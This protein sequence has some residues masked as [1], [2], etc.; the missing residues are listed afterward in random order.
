[1]SMTGKSRRGR[2]VI[3]FRTTAGNTTAGKLPCGGT[4][5]MNSML[6][7]VLVSTSVMAASGDESCP[8]FEWLGQQNDNDC[9]LT[10]VRMVLRILRRVRTSSST[11]RSVCGICEYDASPDLNFTQDASL[12]MRTNPLGTKRV[13]DVREKRGAMPRQDMCA[14]GGEDSIDLDCDETLVCSLRKHAQKSTAYSRSSTQQVKSASTCQRDPPSEKRQVGCVT[15]TLGSLANEDIRELAGVPFDAIL[16]QRREETCRLWQRLSV[17][18]WTVD[19]FLLLLHL[20]LGA[21]CLFATVCEGF[22]AMHVHRPFYKDAEAEEQQRVDRQFSLVRQAGGVVLNRSFSAL[23]L[24]EFLKTEGVIICLVHRKIVDAYLSVMKSRLVRSKQE[25]STLRAYARQAATSATNQEYEGHFVVLVGVRKA[26]EPCTSTPDELCSSPFPPNHSATGPSTRNSTAHSANLS[27]SNGE[28]GVLAGARNCDLSTGSACNAQGTQTHQRYWLRHRSK[29]T[30][31]VKVTGSV[32][33]KAGE[34]DAAEW[35]YF[36][37]DPAE[38]GMQIVDEDV[39]TLARKAA[40]TDED[41][42][43]IY[44]K[45]FIDINRFQ[46]TFSTA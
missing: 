41:L 19:L 35:D 20:G 21:S 28:N 9:G 30:G 7:G 42:I 12:L 26:V 3:D 36:F 37:L 32:Q 22:N 43:F 33:G 13:F 2:S 8:E 4:C 1:M 40:G 38:P 5:A 44:T 17:G 10:C 24:R 27:V 29:E 31:K 25:A 16:A 46:T 23:E 14:V 45:G 6:Q 18:A 39:L 11:A 15:R 34:I